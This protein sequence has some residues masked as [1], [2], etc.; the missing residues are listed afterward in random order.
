MCGGRGS[1]GERGLGGV[2]VTGLVCVEGGGV[3]GEGDW[4]GCW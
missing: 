3:G 2:L 4:V 1:G